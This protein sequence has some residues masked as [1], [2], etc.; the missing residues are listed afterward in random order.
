MTL[1]TLD[2]TV[3]R[4]EASCAAR[5]EWI[6]AGYYAPEF[7]ETLD[8]ALDR[9]GELEPDWDA[10]G[11]KP[12]DR[13]ILVAAKELVRRWPKDL[14]R[15]PKVVPMAKGNLQ[16]EWHDGPRTLELEVESPTTVHYLKWHPEAGTE[17][18]DSFDI[19]DIDKLTTLIR[20]IMRG[21]AHV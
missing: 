18:E 5:D 14:V 1:E 3:R 9:L 10:Q 21:V 17:E 11:A 19:T 12:I 15:P 2:L 16:L 6:A 8:R 13:D 4:T 20:W 7:V